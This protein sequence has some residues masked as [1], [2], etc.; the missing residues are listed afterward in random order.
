MDIPSPNTA[1]VKRD[2]IESATQSLKLFGKTLLVDLNEQSC[3]TE[4][5]CNPKREDTRSF[6]LRVVPVKLPMTPSEDLRTSFS[7]RLPMLG[8][9]TPEMK[10]NIDEQ[11]EGFPYLWLTLRSNGDSS[12]EVLS[13]TP[14]R[15][16]SLYAEQEKLD[17]DEQ[18]KLDSDEQKEGSSSGSNTDIVGDKNWD[19][20]S[21]PPSRIGK[22][23]KT[24][25]SYKLSKRTSATSSK[26][27]R[28]FVPYKR[29][30]AEQVSSTEVVEEREKQR[31]RLCL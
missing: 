31:I 7:D 27:R 8:Y 11:K 6:P 25:S 26:S 29:C 5:T 3:S 30:F 18:K 16:R 4:E 14:V 13:P 19:I 12:P 28:G 10:S 1:Y 15:A 23:V 22:D 9:T 21:C 20:D 24:F 2:L 17:G